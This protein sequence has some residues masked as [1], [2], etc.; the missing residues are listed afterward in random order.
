[1]TRMVGS[2][3]TIPHILLWSRYCRHRAEL[4]CSSL[5]TSDRAMTSMNRKGLDHWLFP[6]QGVCL[7]VSP[8]TG[9]SESSEAKLN[10]LHGPP[11]DRSAEPP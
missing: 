11:V 3:E 7:D 8:A 1:M 6:C 5:T 9:F 4:L 10:L 2:Q